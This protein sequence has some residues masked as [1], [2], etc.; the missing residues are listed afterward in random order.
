M[1]QLV[2]IYFAEGAAVVHLLRENWIAEI[3]RQAFWRAG[4]QW[5]ARAWKFNF[6]VYLRVESQL[7]ETSAVVRSLRERRGA[8]ILR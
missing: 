5:Y 8:E 6:C 4:A 7:A 3:L 2:E 1:H